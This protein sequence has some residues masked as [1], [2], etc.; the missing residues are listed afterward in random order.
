MRHREIPDFQALRAEAEATISAI[1]DFDAKI[2]ERNQAS[3]K[4]IDSMRGLLPA[5]QFVDFENAL[6]NATKS[7]VLK[8]GSEDIDFDEGDV[9]NWLRRIRC[10]IANEVCSMMDGK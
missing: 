2:A 8:D 9:L 10:E 1:K 6:V 7:T 4:L 5:E 3:L